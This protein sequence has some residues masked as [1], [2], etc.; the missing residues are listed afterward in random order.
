MASPVITSLTTATG[1]VG[2]AFSYQIT[3]SGSPTSFGATGLPAG[4]TV[5][6]STGLISGTPTANGPSTITLS[7]TN[8]GGTGTA[9]LTLTV[10]NPAPPAA[11]TRLTVTV[12]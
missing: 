10:T 3:A 2:T 8:S 1:I 6:T 9:S 11:P 5:N 4:L 7:A 12:N